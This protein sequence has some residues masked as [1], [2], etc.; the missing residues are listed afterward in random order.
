MSKTVGPTTECKYQKEFYGRFQPRQLHYRLLAQ[1]RIETSGF[2][3]KPSFIE[4]YNFGVSDVTL[5]TVL[6]G[7]KGEFML[8][9]EKRFFIN[10]YC[11]CKLR[12]RYFLFV[13]VPDRQFGF[14]F[15]TTVLG[16]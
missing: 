11:T 14:Y 7:I 16:V 4:S 9:I 10:T 1:F 5:E 8:R 2:P 12:F 6:R 15:S 3:T 13:S